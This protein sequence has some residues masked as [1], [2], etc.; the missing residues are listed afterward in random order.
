MADALHLALVLW[1]DFAWFGCSSSS[2]ENALY[3]TEHTV[4]AFKSQLHIEID[5]QKQDKLNNW[6]LNSTKTYQNHF[7]L[8][9][10]LIWNVQIHGSISFW[11]FL[12]KAPIL[13]W[14]LSDKELIF[15]QRWNSFFDFK[16]GKIRKTI[17][18]F[19]NEEEKR[20]RNEMASKL[21]SDRQKNA[22]M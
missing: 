3:Q 4:T 10:I 13:K 6:I 22:T 16:L 20:N 11:W 5:L 18:K 14:F 21:H 1:L 8:R 19:D 17:R 12:R 9:M 2:L 15:L 7:L